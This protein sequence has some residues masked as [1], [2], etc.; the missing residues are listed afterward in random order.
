MKKNISI[1]SVISLMMIALFVS[2][3]EDD[4]L[5]VQQ[6]YKFEFSHMPIPVQITKNKPIEI[7]CK[8]QSEGN[9]KEAKYS[10]RYFQKEGEGLLQIGNKSSFF[11]NDNYPLEH[12]EFRL[13]YT[14]VSEGKHQ[15]D[16]YVED[17]FSQ[18]QKVSFE[19]DVKEE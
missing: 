13:Y 18:M 1:L 2:S 16:V 11:P 12:K 7:R 14:A 4:R 5:E 6:A 15:F 10:I 8:L 17:N 9:Y 3:C 19:F